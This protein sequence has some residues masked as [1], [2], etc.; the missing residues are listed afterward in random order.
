MDLY[1]FSWLDNKKAKVTTNAINK[2]YNK[3]FQY[4]VTVALNHKKVGKQ[5]L[6]PV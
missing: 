1:K 2:K 4:A 3:C 6:N 5:K